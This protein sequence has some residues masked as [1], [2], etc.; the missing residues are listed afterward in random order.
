MQNGR[1]NTSKPAG[2]PKVRVLL[3]KVISKSRKQIHFS[4]ASYTAVSEQCG[5]T[6]STLASWSRRSIWII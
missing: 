2:K 6:L 3:V 5:Q 1:S 4:G